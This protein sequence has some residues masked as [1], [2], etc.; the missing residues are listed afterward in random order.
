MADELT[1]EQVHAEMQECRQEI[2]AE[3]EK[4]DR[5]MDK[6]KDSIDNQA[7]YLAAIR[8]ATDELVSIYR[9]GKGFF[10]VWGWIVMGMKGMAVIGA[11]IGAA[12]VFLKTGHTPTK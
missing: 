3:L 7:E 2:Q 1:I 9:A 8:I 12:Y 11:V 4:G 6:L 5:R 10:R